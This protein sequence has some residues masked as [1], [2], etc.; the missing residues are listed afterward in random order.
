[1]NASELARYYDLHVSELW[2][3]GSGNPVFQQGWLEQWWVA[4]GSVEPSDPPIA[5]SVLAA[6]GA[7]IRWRECGEELVGYVST[8][9]SGCYRIPRLAT[10]CLLSPAA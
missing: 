5:T 1:M 2:R 6:G 9:P 8:R 7:G 3:N 4:D 10:E